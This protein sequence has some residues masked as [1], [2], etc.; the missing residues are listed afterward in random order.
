M[1]PT[2][3]KK[4]L[5]HSSTFCGCFSWRHNSKLWLVWCGAR[6]K[7]L[8]SLASHQNHSTPDKL[9][10]KRHP[11]P[12]QSSWS[13]WKC[14]SILACEETSYPLIS[15]VTGM[16]V[17]SQPISLG[18]KRKVTGF[19]TNH[20]PQISKLCWLASPPQGTVPG[21][22]EPASAAA[23]C[24]PHGAAGCSQPQ[25]KQTS[26]SPSRA[27]PRLEGTSED[28]PRQRWAKPC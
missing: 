3:L 9:T 1:S 4:F 22:H 19:G 7:C 17:C 12:C 5:V 18:K 13:F 11:F 21:T 25:R 20:P 2:P 16:P 26:A 8:W 6:Q 10:S 23:H 15:P 24:R 27:E 14:Q 28:G